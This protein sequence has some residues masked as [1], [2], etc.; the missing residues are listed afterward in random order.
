MYQS[1]L[2][3]NEIIEKSGFNEAVKQVKKDKALASRKEAFGEDYPY[4]PPWKKWC[5]GEYSWL[6]SFFLGVP[7]FLVLYYF[8]Y[9]IHM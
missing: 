5:G 4:V 8:L 9:I 2:D 7:P 6:T 1:F 3:V